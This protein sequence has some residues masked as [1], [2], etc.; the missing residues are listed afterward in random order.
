MLERIERMRSE[1]RA[2]AVRANAVGPEL[3][4]IIADADT[5]QV[6]RVG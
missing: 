3:E 1:E 6:L 2:G 4:E 5:H